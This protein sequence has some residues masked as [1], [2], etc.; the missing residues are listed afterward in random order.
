MTSSL[1]EL[2][3]SAKTLFLG[4]GEVAQWKKCLLCRNE[5]LSYSPQHSWT[6]LYAATHTVVPDGMKSTAQTVVSY[7]AP[8]SV[9]DHNSKNKHGGAGEN[10]KA[11]D[12]KACDLSSITCWRENRLLQVVL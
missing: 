5:G 9:R 8:G 2:I 3:V 10:V 4:A 6:K 7:Q 12:A 1:I 11:L